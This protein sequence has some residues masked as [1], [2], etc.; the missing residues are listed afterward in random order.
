MWIAGVVRNMLSSL[1]GQRGGGGCV[2]CGRYYKIYKYSFEQFF[3]STFS[4]K[5]G[6]QGHGSQSPNNYLDYWGA[7]NYI[8]YNPSPAGKRCYDK[9]CLLISIIFVLW[10]IHFKTVIIGQ[11]SSSCDCRQPWNPPSC[12]CGPPK[13]PPPCSC[14]AGKPCSCS[15]YQQ[16]YPAP[17]VRNNTC[18]YLGNY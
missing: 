9:I 15:P 11:Q 1:G 2:N 17:A 7:N 8:R 5:G 10:V 16:H 13:S 6:S 18:N 14:S 12:N 3:L 4:W